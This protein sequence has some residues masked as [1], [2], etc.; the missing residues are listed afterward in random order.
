MI[1]RGYH[2]DRKLNG[3]VGFAQRFQRV[4]TA[5]FGHFDV[6]KNQVNGVLLHP[7]HQLL[8]VVN[9]VNEIAA[10]RQSAG[11]HVPVHFVVIDNQQVA[12]LRAHD[13]FLATS[14]FSIFSLSRPNSTGLVS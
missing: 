6:E 3:G 11:K 2:N 1:L 4:K 7:L 13:S 8:R 14:K 9:D 5:N 12:L 10:P